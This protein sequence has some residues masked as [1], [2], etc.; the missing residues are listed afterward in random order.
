MFTSQQ[1]VC[2][3]F[4]VELVYQDIFRLSYNINPLL[5]NTESPPSHYKQVGLI[6]AVTTFPVALDVVIRLVRSPIVTRPSAQQQH[7]VSWGGLGG[8]WVVQ[9]IM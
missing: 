7:R 8:W 3:N 4:L 5:Q 9:V 6:L 2:N 1:E